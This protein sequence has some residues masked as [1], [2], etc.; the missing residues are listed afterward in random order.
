MDSG[1]PPDEG[2][3]TEP[4]TASDPYQGRLAELLASIELRG[5][6]NAEA[7][8]TQ[9]SIEVRLARRLVRQAERAG[10]AEAHEDLS[11]SSP[12]GQIMVLTNAG[13][14]QLDQLETAADD[15]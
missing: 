12:T 15:S 3:S 9:L 13:R 10:Y 5:I 11:P 1:P 6:D 14:L 7:V 2:P 4:P 8:A